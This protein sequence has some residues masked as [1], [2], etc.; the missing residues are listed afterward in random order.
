[1][2]PH[3]GAVLGQAVG[4][5]AGAVSR[6]TVHVEQRQALVR[7]IGDALQG[8]APGVLVDYYRQH[9]GGEEGPVV[10]RDHIQLVRQLL[11][12]QRQAMAAMTLLVGFAGL[13]CE[14]FDVLWLVHAAPVWWLHVRCYMGRCQGFFNQM[15]VM[16]IFRA[17]CKSCRWAS[18]SGVIRLKQS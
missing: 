10:D 16:R 1:M 6:R 12:G 15:L 18:I 5:E 17:C 9:L 14:D 13:V 2:D 8:L 11:I 4:V 7:G 3:Q